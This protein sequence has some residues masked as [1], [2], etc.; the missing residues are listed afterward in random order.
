MAK[1]VLLLHRKRIYDDGGILEMKLWRVPTEVPGSEH[2][3]KY[4]LYYGE[5]GRRLVGYDN[6]RGKGD[7]RH[8]ADREHRYVFTDVQRLVT[9]FLS[10]VQRVRGGRL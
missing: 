10:D 9:D 7:H 2:Q 8:Y 6:E 1:A 3:L 4:S 5:V